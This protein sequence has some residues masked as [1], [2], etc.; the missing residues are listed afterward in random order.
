M[1]YLNNLEILEH[2]FLNSIISENEYDYWRNML[3]Q[4]YSSSKL[5]KL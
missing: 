1:E 4:Y 5:F 2:D 3:E